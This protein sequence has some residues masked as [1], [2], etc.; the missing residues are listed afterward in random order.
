VAEDRHGRMPLRAVGLILLVCFLWGTNIVSIKYSN[1]GIPPLLTA[2]L[3]NVGAALVLGAWL[4][5]TGRTLIHRD[6]RALHGVV[7][8]IMFG[9]DFLF[10]YWGSLYTS[11]SR[12]VIFANT[13]PLW[14]AL[15]AHFLFPLD[16]LSARK[17]L[18]LAAAF[19][20]IVFVFATRSAELG[21][22]HWVGDVMELAAALVWASTTLYLKRLS[23]H[24]DVPAS[25]TLFYQ[26]AFSL[27]VLFGGSFLFERGQPLELGLGPVLALI[28]QT[29]VV[30]VGSYAL[31][32][33][34]IQHYRVSHL[35]SFTLL[36]PL[37]GVLAGASVLGDTLQASLL[38]GLALVVG[39]IYVVNTT[40]RGPSAAPSPERRGPQKPGT[41]L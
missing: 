30:A 37:F 29:L 2:G 24:Y 8:G 32:Y 40:G 19:A 22:R 41:D 10:F 9:F 7:I 12:V 33:W 3:R 35:A 20:G 13:Q 17:A 11:A 31:W 26:L 5:V 16:R 28:Y 1:E 36:T 15:G 4:A 23:D 21:A 38:L 6:R 25:S 27:P 18:G 39:G 14:V 34:M